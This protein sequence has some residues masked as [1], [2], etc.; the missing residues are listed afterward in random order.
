M[1]FCVSMCFR[2]IPTTHFYCCCDVYINI[3]EEIVYLEAVLQFIVMLLFSWVKLVNSIGQC[4][5][6]PVVSG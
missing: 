4:L 5:L 1:C 3:D 2:H 6:V